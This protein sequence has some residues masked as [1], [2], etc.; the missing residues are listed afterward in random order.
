MGSAYAE[1]VIVTSGHPSAPICQ[2][3]P[4][5]SPAYMASSILPEQDP[6]A[7][8]SASGLVLWITGPAATL[9]KDG[10]PGV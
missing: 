2:T 9:H 1:E 7:R 6:G 8:V 4:D 3:A 10:I 5:C